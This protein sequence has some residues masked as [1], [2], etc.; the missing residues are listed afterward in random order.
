M[1]EVHHTS[2]RA[3][4]CIHIVWSMTSWAYQYADN[5]LVRCDLTKLQRFPE[6]RSLKKQRTSDLSD[7]SVLMKQFSQFWFLSQLLFPFW[8]G[9]TAWH[10]YY[11]WSWALL[12]EPPTVQLLN[13]FAAFY[14]TRTFITVLTRAFHWSLSWAR[15]IQ[16]IPQH[17][18]YLRSILVLSTYLLLG[19]LS[20]LL[21]SG[22]PINNLYVF[23]VCLVRVTC[24]ARLILL[25]LIILIIVG[26][27]YKLWSSSLCSFLQPPVTSS[28]FGPNI[29]LNTPEHLQSVF[30]L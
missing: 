4:I 25:D 17:P 2:L 3:Y 20:G 23:F 13:N 22:F 28:L 30:F 11:S 19:L 5:R 26:E 7:T 15:S 24:P 29:L 8:K 12:E 9:S 1:S 6:A 21:P 27:E 18:T 16:S 10:L 14:G